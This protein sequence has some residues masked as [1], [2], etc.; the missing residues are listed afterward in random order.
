MASTQSR[1][2]TEVALRCGDFV[3]AIGDTLNEYEG[4]Y[5]YLPLV[6][7]SKLFSSSPANLSECPYTITRY[8][9]ASAVSSVIWLS[10]TAWI[11]FIAES[12]EKETQRLG[13][14]DIVVAFRGTML[15]AEWIK[16]FNVGLVDFPYVTTPATNPKAHSGFLNLY[17]SIT[18]SGKPFGDVSMRDQMLNELRR[19]LSADTGA[20]S[21]FP[22][23]IM[24]T[25]HSL[26][27]ALALLAACDI[28]ANLRSAAAATGKKR[29]QG[30]GLTV[31][32]ITFGCP[33]V[34]DK[35]FK[36]NVEY[37]TA[38]QIWRF[39]NT[40]DP[41]PK[42]PA[43]IPI[44]QPYAT[45]VGTEIVLDWMASPYVDA[46]KVGKLTA[47]N[48]DLYLHAVA[49]ASGEDKSAL[50]MATPT[51]VKK[52]LK[53]HAS[54]HPE[55]AALL[56]VQLDDMMACLKE[57]P[58]TLSNYLNE[59]AGMIRKMLE[60]EQVQEEE[61]EQAFTARIISADINRNSAKRIRLDDG[62]RAASAVN[63][64]AGPFGER[65]YALLNKS[66]DILKADYGI[67]AEWLVHPNKDMVLDQDSQKW[68]PRSKRDGDIPTPSN[69][70]YN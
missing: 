67:P 7:K 46:S 53:A 3:T 57:D 51:S 23:S 58:V 10:E 22:V 44:V 33:R 14:R 55:H 34:G 4:D 11:G 13:R 48:L 63:E 65:D 50:A 32:A 9:Y 12:D 17:D 30:V 70:E 28:G 15:N 40:S 20:T 24:V 29:R 21:S 68:L 36:T 49:G 41:V 27:G 37:H 19:L 16:D 66:S 38:S 52:L 18:G 54:D 25:G 45:D 26:G 8:I 47:H 31:S 5:K 56:K 6:G 60:D 39:S 64:P 61:V 62:N 2:D 59:F 43:S 35:Q 42:V 1:P 69:P